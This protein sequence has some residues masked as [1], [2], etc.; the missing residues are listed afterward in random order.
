[1]CITYILINP[2]LV[3]IAFQ[4]QQKSTRMKMIFTERKFSLV[5]TILLPAFFICTNSF[6]QI[7]AGAPANSG[8]DADLKNDNRM[9]GTFTAVGIY[10]SPELTAG[11]GTEIINITNTNSNKVSPAAGNKY[12][13]SEVYMYIRRSGLIIKNPSL[14][15]II[16]NEAISTEGAGYISTKH[17]FTKIEHNTKTSPEAAMGDTV[18]TLNTDGA[19]DMTISLSAHIPVKKFLLW[20]GL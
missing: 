11:T 10:D 9:P 16:S 3:K 20:F 7:I 6:S 17:Y 8:I 12:Y 1:M 4:N 13:T 14:F 18:W 2:N 19:D 15:F 5:Y